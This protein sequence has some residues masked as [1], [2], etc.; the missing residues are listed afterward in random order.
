LVNNGLTSTD[1]AALAINDQGD[2]FAATVSQFGQG[3]GIFRST[4]NGATWTETDN[5]VTAQDIN[6]LAI[7]AAGEIFAGALGGAFVSKD[8]GESWSDISSG[9]I[10]LAG[11]V[12]ALAIDQKGFAL[13]GTAGGG[14]FRSVTSTATASCPLPLPRWRNHPEQWPVESLTLGSQ[15]YEK[16]ELSTILNTRARTPGPGD[17]SLALAHQLIAAKLNIA[18]GSDSTPVASTIEEADALLSGYS[19][20]LPYNVDPGSPDGRTMLGEIKVLSAYNHGELTGG[21]GQ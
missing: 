4:D 2:I 3:G 15:T 17:A 19:G 6:T 9:L 20:K 5:G 14:V 7:N 12:W 16:A 13:A 8:N 1:I 21:C 18:N 10:P 11:N